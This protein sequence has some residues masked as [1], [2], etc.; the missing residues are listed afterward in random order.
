M[1]PEDFVSAMAGLQ[2]RRDVA[3]TGGDG[4]SA[5]S[6]RNLL[7]D[8]D[9]LILDYDLYELGT[10][11]SVKAHERV[12]GEEVAY[13]ARCYSRCRTIVGSTSSARTLST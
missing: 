2:E 5:G 7:D 4:R 12:T 3:R 8:V 1:P 10:K 9:V 6:S 11:G 13:L